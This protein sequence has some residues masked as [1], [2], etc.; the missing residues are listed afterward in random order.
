MMFWEETMTQYL[1][2]KNKKKGGG[3]KQN[4]I[5]DIPYTSKQKLKADFFLVT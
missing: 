5:L 4:R 1:F 3:C 2:F